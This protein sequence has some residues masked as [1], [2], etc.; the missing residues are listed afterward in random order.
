[1][2]KFAASIGVT[3]YTAT[4]NRSLIDED[5]TLRQLVAN[6]TLSHHVTTMREKKNIISLNSDPDFEPY[7]LPDTVCYSVTPSG[8]VLAKKDTPKFTPRIDFYITR[9]CNGSWIHAGERVSKQPNATMKPVGNGVEIFPH[10]MSASLIVTCPT[11]SETFEFFSTSPCQRSNPNTFFYNTHFPPYRGSNKARTDNTKKFLAE[12]FAACYKLL[13][14]V[15]WQQASG[16]LQAYSKLT[17]EPI[18]LIRSLSKNDVVPYVQACAPSANRR[19]PIQISSVPEND[20]YGPY[21]IIN[22]ET[23]TVQ[24]HNGSGSKMAHLA[25]KSKCKIIKPM[26]TKC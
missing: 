1:M 23:F 19:G 2:L 20:P 4:Q 6:Y 17:Q 21:Y 24:L 3:K 9:S 14:H 16:R 7:R 8:V 12:I 18:A 10:D 22:T 11:C 13:P 15:T 25:D 26:M 5:L